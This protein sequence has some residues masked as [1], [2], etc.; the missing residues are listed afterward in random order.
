MFYKLLI[1][2]IG[3]LFIF[4][5]GFNYSD[6][7]VAIAKNNANQ[8][9]LHLNYHSEKQIRAQSEKAYPKYAREE[10]KKEKTPVQ[11]KPV[12]KKEEAEKI[13]D[14]KTDSNNDVEKQTK[15]DSN[16]SVP[17]IKHGPTNQKLVALTFDDGP[18]DK[19]TPLVLDLLKEYQVKATFFVI[20][21]NVEN[22]PSVTLRITDEGHEIA[23]H[24]WDH[25]RLTLLSEQEIQNEI[26]KTNKIIESVTGVS[27]TLVR[28]PFGDINNSG[29]IAINK[30]G[31]KIVNWSV[32][33][34][35][36]S[37]LSV[38]GI[39]SNVKTE[40]SPGGIIL[41]HSGGGKRDNTVS[42][43]PQIIETLQ[44]EGYQFV[45]LTELCW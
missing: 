43:L 38:D 29:K 7:I 34:R 35:D 31:N 30:L 3:F 8:E 5:L 2:T 37:G 1:A 39:L 21:K 11:P 17:V 36:W 6:M 33:T 18:D 27:P 9:S 26:I 20:G 15:T 32:D 4:L 25:Q 28:P 22:L 42:S 13:D 45:T 10:P 14:K 23:N 24:T 44:K 16:T 40:I 12:P 19:Y 41:M